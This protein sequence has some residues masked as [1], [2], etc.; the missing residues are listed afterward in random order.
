LIFP[1]IDAF[2]ASGFQA[3]VC[4]IGTGPAGMA[5]ALQLA[6]ARIPVVMLEAGTD[7]I[8]A[9]SQEFYRGEVDGDPYFD[10]DT[11]RI[12]LLGGC[13]NHWAGWCRVM[14]AHDFETR[15]WI[16]ASGWP[17]KRDDLQPYL[18]LVHNMLDLEDF[19]PNVPISDDIDW[20][21]LIKSPAVHVGEKYRT[22]LEKSDRI[23]VVMNTMATDLAGD[24]TKVTAVNLWSRG[25][26]AGSL[27]TD[28]VVVCTGGLENSRLLQWSNEKTNGGVVPDAAALGK[29][30]MEHPQFE[31]AVALLF[32]ESAFEWDDQDEAFFSPTRSAM[33]RLG[34]MNFGA[35]LIKSPYRGVKGLVADLACFAPDTSEWIASGFG[36]H[37]RCA[38]QIYL[39][40][41]QAPLESNH[42][43]LSQTDK[44]PAGIPRI[45]LHW[46]K[47]ELE[48]RT[49]VEGLRLFGETLAAKDL[50]RLRFEDWVLNGDAYPENQELAGHH[51]MGGT[52][53]GT[54]PL[55]S[56][57]DADCKVH[58][59]ANL[60][61]GGSSVFTTSGQC[62][63]TTTL[64]ALA[65][66]LGDH[67]AK[68]VTA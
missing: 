56:V 40:W 62:N 65:L 7:E 25:V 6:Q 68:V 53:M 41:E 2:R 14:D 30:W 3:R 33:E 19:R 9:E 18:G 34:I 28:H 63:P 43:T 16:P 50:G 61:I 1:D 44:D 15:S 67:L 38:A 27:V 21:Q 36:A 51:H 13:S 35:R 11:T 60:W 48:R 64:T 54:D 12:R 24:G 42:I 66:R 47:G 31:P 59:M 22:D 20:V 32:D 45:I 52:R 23:A 17:I 49:M 39:G 4:V 37:L 46:K 29:Y 10:L 26:A 5:V 58:G 55:K 8:T 57:V